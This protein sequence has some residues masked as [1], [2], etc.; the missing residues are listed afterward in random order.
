MGGVGFP[1][2]VSFSTVRSRL[3]YSAAALAL[4]LGSLTWWP[5]GSTASINAPTAGSATTARVFDVSKQLAEDPF[6]VQSLVGLSLEETRERVNDT[7]VEF[8]VVQLQ[9]ESDDRN[10]AGARLAVSE[11]RDE[12]VEIAEDTVENAITNYR[13][14]DVDQNLLELRDLNEG[15]R[16]NALGDAAITADTETFE[17]YRNKA[18]DLQLAEVNL[19]AEV[20][21]NDELSAQLEWLQ[22]RLESEQSWLADMEERY[23]RDA[24]HL[25]SV[26]ES[27]WDQ[28]L[29]TKQGLYLRTCPV[30]GAHN[31]I[32]S[33]GFPRSGGRRHKG[34]DII[35]DIGVPIVAPVNGTVEFRSNRVGGRSFH[36][37]GENGNYFYGTHLSAYGDTEGEVRAGQVIGYVG[38]DG[39]A[40]GIPHLHFE[41]HPGGR[42]TQINPF[43]DTAAVCDGAQFG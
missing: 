26:R 15:L 22:K 41:I 29:G 10:L 37:Q 4:A 21:E 43:A 9:K 23:I 27:T 14:T 12:T 8:R 33:W 6:N 35:A 28:L 1:V 32:D 3:P 34:V 24:A 20:A 42:G 18:K 25:E 40:A 2:D 13:Q 38:D 16:A 30:N 5:T 7:A 39:N 17:D 36:L 31:F 11:L 19:G